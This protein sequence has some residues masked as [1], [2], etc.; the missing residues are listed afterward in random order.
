MLWAQN[1]KEP[2]FLLN[3]KRGRGEHWKK[4]RLANYDEV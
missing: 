3:E 4:I 1:P 2:R